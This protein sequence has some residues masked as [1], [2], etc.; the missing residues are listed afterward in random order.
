MTGAAYSFPL[1]LIDPN[2]VYHEGDDL[3]VLGTVKKVLGE[4]A[5]EP[6]V[7][8]PASAFQR[9]SEPTAVQS[10]KTLLKNRPVGKL[11]K[12][13]GRISLFIGRTNATLIYEGEDLLIVYPAEKYLSVDAPAGAEVTVVGTFDLEMQRGREHGVLR[14]AR[15]DRVSLGR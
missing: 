12:A 8:R 13:R 1:A 5:I 14:E 6:I 10:I 2:P 11:V 3:V 7:V 9:Q 15:I 4:R